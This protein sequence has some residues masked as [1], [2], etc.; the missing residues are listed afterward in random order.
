MSDNR[1]ILIVED[2]RGIRKLLSD[3]LSEKGYEVSC[4][5]EGRAADKLLHEQRFDCILMDMMLPFH[6]GDALIKELRERKDDLKAARTPVIVI[7]AKSAMDTQLSVLKMGADDYITKPFNLDEVL[8]RIEVVLRRS[9]DGAYTGEKEENELISI[10]GLSYNLTL[11][12]VTYA[13][14]EIKLTSKEQQLLY[15]FLKNPH[16]TFSKANLYETVWED[17]YY[18]EDNTINVHMS[19]LRSKL[20]KACGQEFIETVWGIGYRLKPE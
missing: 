11:N 7:S 4:V 12:T 14:K 3:Y 18:Y 10:N 9:A 13:D 17:T 5:A 16:K 15:L 20:K 6:S 2:D 8:V 19:N 1:S